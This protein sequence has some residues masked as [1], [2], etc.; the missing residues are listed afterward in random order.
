MRVSKII[1]DT[2]PLVSPCR[3]HA[4]VGE[5]DIRPFGLDRLEEGVAILARGD[6]LDVRIRLEESANSLAHEVVVLGQND[7]DR[8]RGKHTRSLDGI[9]LSVNLELG[10]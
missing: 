3:R 10:G 5:H 8:Q 7:A 2:N 4:D 9:H 6:E 1:G